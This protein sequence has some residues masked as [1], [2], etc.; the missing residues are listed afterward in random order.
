MHGA[1]DRRSLIKGTAMLAAAGAWKQG[2]AMKPSEQASHD[3]WHAL[4]V[5]RPD[6]LLDGEPALQAPAPDSMGV[7][8]AVKGLANGF[9]EVGEDPALRE[10]ETRRFMAEGLPLAQ[11]DSRVLRV[12]LEGLEPG[13][14]Y[15]YRAGAATIASSGGYWTKPS[16]IV[17]GAVHSF[18]TPGESA[19]SHFALMS[20]THEDFKQ[21]AKIVAK[22]KELGVPLVVWNGDIPRSMVKE[23]EDLVRCHLLPPGCEG[24]AADVPIAFNRGN[25]DFRGSAAAQLNTVSMPRRPQE[26]DSRFAALD[27]NFAFRMGEIAIIGLDTGEDKPDFHPAAG[28]QSRFTQ[29][30]TLQSEWLRETLERRDIASAP[31]AVAIVHIPIV[32]F[33]PGANPGTILEDYAEWQKE[34][35]ELWGP[36][37]TAHGVQLVLAGHLHRYMHVPPAAGASWATIVAGGRGVSTFQTLIE[38]KTEDGRLLVRVH[39][40]D[41]GTIAGEHWFD[42]RM[43]G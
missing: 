42:K 24:F 27:R 5:P 9:V 30:R 7:A 8:F 16:E 11:I 40:T 18:T 35:A 36:T 32:E 2:A 26:R 14:K 29:Y 17:W 41:K 34:C 31:F 33:R 1:I 10:G 6:G 21:M 20:D 19:P 37:L 25:H 38:C 28:G 3:R 12:R 39:N 22:Y 13:K 43:V 4:E 23:R 15:W